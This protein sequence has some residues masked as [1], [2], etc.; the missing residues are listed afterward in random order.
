MMAGWRSSEL[1]EYVDLMIFREI[2]WF[3]GGHPQRF[4]VTLRKHIWWSDDKTISDWTRLSQNIVIRQC[5]PDQQSAL[6]WQYFT[7]VLS[8]GGRVFCLTKHSSRSMRKV[9]TVKKIMRLQEAYKTA[10]VIVD[11]NRHYACIKIEANLKLIYVNVMSQVCTY[12]SYLADFFAK[13]KIWAKG[14]SLH[15]TSQNATLRT[16]SSTDRGHVISSFV[17]AAP[18]NKFGKRK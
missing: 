9:Q 15:P 11:E 7:G 1:I 13:I 12:G 16:L 3:S 4:W 5:L 6:H 10:S 17:M 2:P 18:L 8:F 14:G